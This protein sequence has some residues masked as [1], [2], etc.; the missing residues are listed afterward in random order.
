[1]VR[2]NA[3]FLGVPG[4]VPGSSWEFLVGPGEMNARLGCNVSKRSWEHMVAMGLCGLR[5]WCAQW[6]W[7]IMKIS[8][9]QRPPKSRPLAHMHRYNQARDAAKVAKVSKNRITRFLNIE[10]TVYYQNRKNTISIVPKNYPIVSQSQMPI[11]VRSRSTHATHALLTPYSRPT[12]A[13]LTL[14]SRS[15]STPANVQPPLGGAPHTGS[16]GGCWGAPQGGICARI[17]TSAIRIGLM[18]L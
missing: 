8:R 7:E 13:L 17:R 12:H 16:R 2:V 14:Y 11:P 9:P 15:R 5:V 1:M 4:R 10:L 6:L 3:G 18:A